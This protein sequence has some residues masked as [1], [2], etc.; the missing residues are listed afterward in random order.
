MTQAEIMKGN[1]LIDQSNDYSLQKSWIDDTVFKNQTRT[2][3]KDKK[4]F[5]NDNMRSDFHKKFMHRY[6]SN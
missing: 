5:I 2:E 3:P 4:R 6:I 1:P